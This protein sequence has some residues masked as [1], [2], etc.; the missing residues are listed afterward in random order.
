M[1]SVFPQRCVLRLRLC[2]SISCLIVYDAYWFSFWCFTIPVSLDYISVG[3]VHFR[4][5][6]TTQLSVFCCD[7][8][9][10]VHFCVHAHVGDCCNVPFLRWPC[11]QIFMKLFWSH[12]SSCEVLHFSSLFPRTV[13]IRLLLFLPQHLE[14]FTH[15]ANWIWS[16]CG[17]IFSRTMWN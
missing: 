3:V 6:H 14:E 11:G 16:F 5:K 13:C 8:L 7:L 1:T 2:W 15:K 4:I 17:N 10:L 9:I 12:K